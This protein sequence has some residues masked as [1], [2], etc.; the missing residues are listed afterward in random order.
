MPNR[1]LRI[2]SA[3]PVHPGRGAPSYVRVAIEHIGLKGTP[4]SQVTLS[5]EAALELAE[6]LLVSANR[7]AGANLRD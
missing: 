5:V 6:D 4:L 7:V 2:L 1:E 3:N